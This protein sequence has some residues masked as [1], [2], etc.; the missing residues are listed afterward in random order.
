ML[1]PPKI[2][3]LADTLTEKTLPVFDE[4]TPKIVH[5]EENVIDREKRNARLSEVN[6]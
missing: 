4:A 5:E 2:N 6:K 1:K 3:A